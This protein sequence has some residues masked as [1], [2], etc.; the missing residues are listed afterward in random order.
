MKDTNVQ[1]GMAEAPS[2]LFQLVTLKKRA[3]FTAAAG[4]PRFATP[5]FTMLRGPEAG[6]AP[7]RAGLRFGF[8]VT[9]KV[10]NAVER[11]RIR[12]RLREAVC[13]ASSRFPAKP[14][15]LVI[16]ARRA[17]IERSFAELAD[18]IAR[19]VEALA[20]REPRR[21]GKPPAGSASEN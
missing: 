20:R 15:N 13:A 17:A 5:G 11:N 2:P 16:L 6:I 7:D 19:A 8:T 14:M 12:R 4:G 18:D 9:K 1:G 3:D 10:G 21:Q